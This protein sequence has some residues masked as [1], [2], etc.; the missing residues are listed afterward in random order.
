MTPGMRSDILVIGGGIVG[1]SV[2]REAALRGWSVRLVE[3]GD[4]AGGAS[5]RSTKLLHG[6]LR[7]LERGDLRLVREALREREITW[8]LAPHLARPLG[9]VFLTRHRT[10]PGPVAARVGVG[11]YDLLAGRSPLARGRRLGAGDVLALLG[12]SDRDIWSGGVQ[13]E[14]R[15]TDDARLTLAIARDAARRGAEIRTGSRVVELILRGRFV[16]GALVEDSETGERSEFHASVVVNA[17]GPW[18]DALRSMAGFTSPSVRPS[19]GTHLVLPDLGLRRAILYSGRQRGH[20][21]FAIPW[22]GATLFGTTD[23]ETSIADDVQPSDAEVRMLW[24]EAV[25]LFPG[26]GLSPD[27]VLH[28][29][30]GL[31]PL[32]RG[33]GETLSLSREHRILSERGVVSV[34]GGKLTTWRSMAEDAIGEVARALGKPGGPHPSSATDPLPGGGTT[35]APDDPRLAGVPAPVSLRWL[36]RYGGEALALAE[37]VRTDPGLG[38]PVAGGAIARLVEVDFAVRHEFARALEDVLVRRMGLEQDRAILEAAAEPAAA[39]MRAIL[40][41]SVE[42]EREEVR[43]LRER[44]AATRRQILSALDPNAR[45]PTSP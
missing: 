26:A 19:R 16:T 27:R 14:D 45:P 34:I 31:R 24:D 17:A 4:L 23:V 20:R 40:G 6:G 7:Y 8:R 11:L 10:W 33:S 35:L 37:A 13:F 36:D 9:F 22:R 25:R 42:R 32:A 18:A 29:F 5:S 21:L 43:R 38:E 28:A 41:W 15:Q 30:A 3:R 12:S 1:C 2:A 39:R 44:G